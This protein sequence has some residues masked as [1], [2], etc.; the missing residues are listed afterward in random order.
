MSSAPTA[1][2]SGTCEHN[3]VTSTFQKGWH[4]ASCGVQLLSLSCPIPLPLISQAVHAIGAV[5]K[6]QAG[7]HP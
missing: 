7:V 3:E 4:C 2:S 6:H 1:V 5:P